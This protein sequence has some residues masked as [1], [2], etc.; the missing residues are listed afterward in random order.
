MAPTRPFKG[1][2]N[3]SPRGALALRIIEPPFM[4]SE[5]AF[6]GGAIDVLS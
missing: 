4:C 1:I 2:V 6:D 5:G 3:T